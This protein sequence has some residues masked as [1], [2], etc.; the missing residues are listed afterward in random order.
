MDFVPW[1]PDSTDA[2]HP[3]TQTISQHVDDILKKSCSINH[4]SANVAGIVRIDPDP[5]VAPGYGYHIY[6]VPEPTSPYARQYPHVATVFVPEAYPDGIPAIRFRSNLR[7]SE[8][9]P[10][11]FI[12]DSI[13][14]F[15]LQEGRAKVSNKNCICRVFGDDYLYTHTDNNLMH[16]IS[17]VFYML[18]C[19]VPS[20]NNPLSDTSDD[21]L[22]QMWEHHDDDCQCPLSAC[23]PCLPSEF[24][25]TVNDS[26]KRMRLLTSF[27]NSVEHLPA[28]MFEAMAEIHGEREKTISSWLGL[29]KQCQMYQP[30]SHIILPSVTPWRI[31]QP[32]HKQLQSDIITRKQQYSDALTILQQWLDPVLYNA[33]T[34]HDFQQ[35]LT[36][37]VHCEGDGIYTIPFLRLDVC[38]KLDADI[39]AFERSDLPKTRPN[40]MN[41]YGVVLDDIGLEP[42][43][44]LL[45]SQVAN[46]LAKIL[47]SEEVHGNLPLDAHHAFVVQYR[48]D[49]DRYLDMHTDDSEVTINVNLAD[50]FEGSDLQF[51][52][53]HGDD[54]HR[55]WTLAYMHQKGRA[56][57][58]K[59]L[60]RHGADIILSG[61]RSNLILWCRSC[62]YRMSPQWQAQRIRSQ[63]EEDPDFVCL[64]S[65]HDIDYEYWSASSPSAEDGNGDDGNN[66]KSL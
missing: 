64:S 37:I 17:L 52:G 9:L 45:T 56:V 46:P 42:F 60:Q 8:V 50:Q 40:S 48:P 11:S 26:N 4:D 29:T 32:L 30:Q 5:D 58:H 7:H 49:Q 65:T 21:D 55:K 6:L 47:F 34:S 44:E 31:S 63:S 53:L 19:P 28:L 25:D 20:P 38:D 59:G 39:L 18:H 1:L 24:R 14:K 33:L 66:T 23:M 15:W 57:V 27:K 35:A 13:V 16:V 61:Y 3:Q 12:S 43:F 51:C 10:T 2:P 54:S 62:R 41:N 36:D 22:I